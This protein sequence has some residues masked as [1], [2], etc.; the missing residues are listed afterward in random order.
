MSPSTPFVDCLLTL[1][2]LIAAIIC[3]RE[4]VRRE[5]DGLALAK[6]VEMQLQVAKA[7]LEGGGSLG[8]GFGISGPVDQKYRKMSRC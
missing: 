2:V 8:E 7:H 6:R 5:A 1:L 4:I 3:S